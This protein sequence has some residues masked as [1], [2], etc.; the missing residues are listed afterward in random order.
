VR[1][2]SDTHPT[3]FNGARAATRRRLSE[4]GRS[5]R[6]AAPRRGPLCAKPTR[7]LSPAFAS[8]K[9]AAGPSFGHE[10]YDRDPSMGCSSPRRAICGDDSVAEVDQL[11][12]G[13]RETRLP[14]A[15]CTRDRHPCVAVAHCA[16]IVHLD[17][18]LLVKQA[19][20][21]LRA[22]GDAQGWC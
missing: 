8:I 21:A 20:Q 3:G 1:S 12:I 18:A 22:K 17:E 5:S 7:R 4:P 11:G 19:D 14:F 9:E 6:G 2:H 13:I 10:R 15:D 16:R